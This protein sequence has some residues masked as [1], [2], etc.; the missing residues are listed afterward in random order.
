MSHQPMAQQ[1]ISRGAIM[2]VVV[3]A[4]GYFVDIYDLILFSVVRVRSL[5]GIGV[6]DGDLQSLGAT[7]INWQM[8]GMLLGGIAW[9]VLGDKWGRIRV[10][11]GSIIL[12]SVANI[13]NGFIGDVPLESGWHPLSSALGLSQAIDQYI[14][15]R[16]IAGIGLAGEL[17]AGITLV[18][19]LL[20]R[21]ARGYGTTI[22]AGFGVC[23]GIA[24]VSVSTLFE[25]RTSYFVGGAMGLCLLALRVGVV[26]SGMF[27]VVAAS[28]HARGSVWMLFWPPRRLL[29]YASVVAV[30]IPIWFAAAIPVTFAPEFA[31]SVGITSPMSAAT[32]VLWFY[33]GLAVGDI[34]SGLL[35]QWLRSRKRALAIF[36]AWT[37]LTCF[38]GYEWIQSQPEVWV[39]ATICGLL[40]FGCGY[41]AVFVTIGAEQFG[42]NL[43]ATAATTAPNFV[44]GSVPLLTGSWLFLQSHGLSITTAA[45]IV[46]TIT[47]VIAA[48][49]LWH[50]RETYG[51]DLDF[52][53][54]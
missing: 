31:K 4:L 26:E 17:G 9:G 24:A 23:G 16:F 49:G 13:L 50:L 40:G 21:H 7:L 8:F 28:N 52:I 19:E 25:W 45:A 46:G 14:V 48:L 39:Y 15:L 32:A 51:H 43:R 35:S 42:T 29:R 54:S 6:L 2:A 27:N 36:L 41:W 12:Y 1:P 5:K 44:R 18:S 34:T 3:A 10:L 20:G 22:V 33:V 37:A 30:A 47:L 53:E 38:G 11:F